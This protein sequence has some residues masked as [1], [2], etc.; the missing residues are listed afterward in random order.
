[1]GIL[2]WI[3]NPIG[4][5]INHNKSK[6]KQPNLNDQLAP[7]LQQFSDIATK[8]SGQ[9]DTDYGKASAG[10]DEALNYFHK[11]MS[12]SRD[13]LLDTLDAS[14]LNKAADEQ[15]QQN[16]ETAPRGGAR[17]ATAA[18]LGFDKFAQLNSF[19]QNLRSQAPGQLA[20]IAQAI[21]NMAQGKLSAATGSLGSASNILFGLE[22]VKQQVADRHA[23]LLGSIFQA[24]GTIAG[25]VAC[26][27][28][29]TWI[30]TPDKGYRLLREIQVGDRISIPVG[31]DG[32]FS[33]GRVIRKETKRGQPVFELTCN[34]SYIKGT[35]SH[36]LVGVDNSEIKFEELNGK[37]VIVPF[38][39]DDKIRKTNLTKFKLLDKPEDVAILKIND[40][41][42]N[43]NYITNGFI[44][45]DADCLKG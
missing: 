15:T 39:I 21:S 2:S 42:N 14:N 30:L 32:E 6:A 24:V 4:S 1:M 3:F 16:Y 29:D 28:L 34:G 25:A 35:S 22:S 11:I 44:S 18:N 10:Y 13:E 5:I 41:K 12:G 20:N 36:V 40:E 17:A 33:E 7:Y 26:N 38:Y 45:V 23:Q 9:A 43:Y 8:Y 27:T 37:P 31:M 19:L